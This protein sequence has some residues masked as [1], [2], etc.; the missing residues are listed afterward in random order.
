ERR[1]SLEES[2]RTYRMLFEAN[3]APMWTYD[4]ETLRILTVNRAAVEKYGYTP[5]EFLA[6]TVVEFLAEEEREAI[7]ARIRRRQG[8]GLHTDSGSVR[9]QL[10]NGRLIDVDVDV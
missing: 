5:V 10:K 8:L 7:A 3:P 2:E 1:R 6:M 4:R 9:H